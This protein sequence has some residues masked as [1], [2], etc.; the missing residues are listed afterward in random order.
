MNLLV[1][2]DR[3]FFQK[4]TNA[5]QKEGINC[6]H[7]LSYVDANSWMIRRE[8][9]GD[10]CVIINDRGY[11]KE[12]LYTILTVL[13]AEAKEMPWIIVKNN[14]VDNY[15]ELY[16][17]R[18]KRLFNDAKYA[19]DRIKAILCSDNYNVAGIED[20]IVQDFYRLAEINFFDQNMHSVMKRV[21]I[22]GTTEDESNWFVM[23]KIFE[24][25]TLKG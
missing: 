4:A 2:G 25:K 9:N 20:K 23:H 1:V 3:D 13:Q 12:A 7:E 24:E 11:K 18:D 10:C 22:T 19:S 15:L 8:S 6:E 17:S 16:H 14:V 5:Y 21:R